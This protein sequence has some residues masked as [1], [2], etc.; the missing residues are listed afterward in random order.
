MIRNPPGQEFLVG[1]FGDNLEFISDCYKSLSEISMEREYPNLNQVELLVNAAAFLRLIKRQD[2]AF[3][4]LLRSADMYDVISYAFRSG[5]PSFNAH[6]GMKGHDKPDK[7]YQ[8]N[9]FRGNNLRQRIG[10][11]GESDLHTLR[12]KLLSP[13]SDGH[14]LDIPRG[15]NRGERIGY[16]AHDIEKIISHYPR[17]YVP[18]GNGPPEQPGHIQAPTMF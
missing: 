15:K 14:D 4:S 2:A 6:T 11:M 13:V 16:Y 18:L 3:L 1:L 8:Q 9:P 17:T 7:Y 10:R 5:I 12:M